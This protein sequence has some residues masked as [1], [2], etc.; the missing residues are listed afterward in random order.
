MG[1]VGRLRSRVLACRRGRRG[2][3]ERGVRT[4]EGGRW[5]EWGLGEEGRKW[6]W[7]W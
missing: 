4:V 2:R 5:K 7:W 6:W 1:L 3:G